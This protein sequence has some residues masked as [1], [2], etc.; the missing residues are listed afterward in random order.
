[1]TMAAQEAR[2][3]AVRLS[4]R[5]WRLGCHHINLFLVRGRTA[6]AIFEAGITVTTDLVLTQLD[7]LGVARRQV[8]HLVLSHAHADHATGQAGLL[9]GLPEAELV[10]S[11]ASEEFLARPG[12]AAL[13][14]PK[15]AITS[16]EVIA[17]EGLPGVFGGIEPLLP[18]RRRLAEAGETLDL[19]GATLELHPAEGHAPGGFWAWV[20]EDGAALVSDAAGFFCLGGPG[21]P[22]CFAG[23]RRYLD[24][25]AA[26]AARRPA[27]LGLGHQA[28]LLGGEVM[29][30]LEATRLLMEEVAAEVRRRHAA[31][32]G[33]DQQVDWI[34]ERFY[35]GELTI[36]G[37]EG[38]RA[39]TPF[40]VKRALEAA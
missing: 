19:G 17:R 25:L 37:E 31:G 32:Q 1:M 33:M 3:A 15:D 23:Y 28:A 5:V 20:P 2:P 10:L 38:M 9:A 6:S 8:R 40:V 22:L 18:A 39:V 12:T 14:Q 16:M 24:D 29:P 26:I 7:A 4:E 11:R 13:W 35:E 36:Y 21:Y 27:V 30:Y 34:M